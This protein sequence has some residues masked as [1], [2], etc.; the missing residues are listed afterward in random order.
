METLEAQFDMAFMVCILNEDNTISFDENDDGTCTFLERV[1]SLY[2]LTLRVMQKSSTLRTPT[3][4]LSVLN[5]VS[6]LNELAD[7][8][9]R[10]GG[11]F[12][13]VACVWFFLIVKAYGFINR[14]PTGKEPPIAIASSDAQRSLY[15]QLCNELVEFHTEATTTGTAFKLPGIK[16]TGDAAAAATT[17]TTTWQGMTFPCSPA[18]AKQ[19][20]SN[21]L[22][23][24]Q[25]GYNFVDGGQQTLYSRPS[26]DAKFGEGF[27]FSEEVKKGGSSQEDAVDLS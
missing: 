22:E 23:R 18:V 21:M 14:H 1:H 13:T 27:Y 10:S 24:L 19:Y 4:D 7:E 3:V 11:T 26:T 2:E 15:A 6:E 9:E 16:E 8:I 12:L 25:K 17:T 5:G 20:T